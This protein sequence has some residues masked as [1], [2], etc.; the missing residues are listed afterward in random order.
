[1]SWLR[2]IL[3]MDENSNS[4][5]GSK[6]TKGCHFCNASDEDATLGCKKCGIKFCFACATSA[7]LARG[8]ASSGHMF[9]GSPCTQTA[10]MCPKCGNRQ[11]GR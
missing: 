8:T 3:G 9:D 10:L 2:K 4:N 1:M 6:T 7:G 5:N 11:V